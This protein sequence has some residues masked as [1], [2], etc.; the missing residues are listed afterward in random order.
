VVNLVIAL[1]VL[2]AAG[3]FYWY[4][5]RALPELSGTITASVSQPVTIRRD[6]LGV[7]HIQ[8]KSLEDAWFAQG[9]VIA[10]DRMWQ[11]DA[12][13]RLAAG[14]LSEII[15]AKTLEIDRDARRLRL[16][17]T[18]ESIY[19][20]LSPEERV[21]FAAYARGVNAW[22]TTHRGRYGF[23]FSVLGYDPRPW[24]AVDSILAGVQ[25]FRTLAGDWKSKKTKAQML[26]SGEADKVR[27]LFPTRTGFELAPGD[28]MRPGSNG[29]AVAGSHTADGKPLV[30]N[31]MHLDFGLP[32]IWYQV[33]L[34]APGL[35]VSGVTLPG[36]PG[37]IAG[38]NDRIAWGMTNLGF[39]VQDLY[40]EKFD[41]RTGQYV[42]GTQ[43]T[44][45]REERELIR[46]KGL[47]PEDQQHWITRHGPVVDQVN[48]G[49]LA[50][51]WTLYDPSLF[52]NVFI[53]VNQARNWDEFQTAISR[54]GG[55][56]QNFVY[57][58]VDG[59]IGYHAAG[60]LPIRKS[61]VG[62]LP[63]EGASGQYEWEGYIP[64]DELPH[65]WNPPGGYIVTA[66]Q[67]PFPTDYPYKVSGNFATHYRS[68]QILDLL[69]AATQKLKPEDTLRIQ[70]DVYSGFNRFIGR[71]VV[72]AWDKRGDKSGPLA[73]TV[74]L[75]RN[76]DGQ[77]DK[78]RPQPLLTTLIFQHVRKAIADRAV[79]N[80]GGQYE[81]QMSPAV[82][83]RVLRERPEGWFGD[84][85]ELL[86]RSL[87][88]AVEEGQRLFGSDPKGWRWGRYLFADIA[89]PIAG[90][91][92]RIGK[93]FGIG[94]V[95]MSGSAT[96]VKQT[97]RRMGPSERMNVSVGA[98]DKSLMNIVAGE[99]GHFGSAHYRDQ[100]DAY[101]NGTSFPMQFST[102]DAKSTLTLNPAR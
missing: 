5:Y 72:A 94:P 60:K 13:R 89:H 66:N 6:A 11:M 102:V 38:H 88:E 39:D 75:L 9:Y 17:R 87:A 33:H 65:A 59:N 85:H 51:K 44:R 76:W 47:V 79:P 74:D 4:F 7:P 36:T 58:D 69:H 1:L 99:S 70:K 52:H 28:D 86:L 8:A 55:P 49:V 48:G 3:V 14:D 18:A 81:T 2:T 95:P 35:N 98:W 92:P 73:G 56:G 80:A 27:Y 31:D 45:A 71:Q 62:D 43:V 77:M 61:Y 41:V 26:S 10:A 32:G 68:Q 50:L 21:P 96:S 100:W 53:E 15:G 20:S 25:M 82:V 24:S 19:A 57:G 42:A 83:E 22:I 40:V 63:V 37:I 54:F 97:S 67:N 101:Y 16:R 91:I 78:D 64:F 23:E 46:I 34:E 30:S 12:F 29:W 93:Y 84:Y 90:G